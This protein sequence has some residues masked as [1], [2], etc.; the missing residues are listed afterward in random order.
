MKNKEKPEKEN[1]KD[2]S[3][4]IIQVKSKER[5]KD[6]GE[7]FTNPRE[8]KAM[9]DLV[10]DESYRIE[11][12]F[13]EPACGTGNFLVEIL[14]RK[15]KTVSEVATNKSEWVNLA[16]VAVGAIYGIDIQ[17]DNVEESIERLL[18]IVESKCVELYESF[19]E[20]EKNA[21]EFIMKEN[22]IHGNGLTG[23]LC[24]ANGEESKRELMFSEWDFSSLIKENYVERKL[25]SMNKMIAHNKQQESAK[26]ISSQSGSLFALA[27]Q[28]QVEESM[29]PQS[30]KI[31][32]NFI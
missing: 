30:T 2:N 17:K 12:T 8:V 24:K 18:T 14:D 16:L 11:A 10:K 21:F 13:L 29:K 23:M 26:K 6:F 31:H 1:S 20:N 27:P 9:L 28:K 15:L 7:V 4:E 3:E 19:S 25:F 22:I 5:V 32:E